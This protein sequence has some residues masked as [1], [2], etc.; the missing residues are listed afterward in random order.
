MVFLSFME[1]RNLSFNIIEKRLFR[2]VN[3][4]LEGFYSHWAYSGW[5]DM[6]TEGWQKLS[7]EFNLQPRFSVIEN[8]KN[9]I[10]VSLWLINHLCFLKLFFI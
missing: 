1:L 4:Y 6:A 7:D 10:N 3:N 5:V 2:F 8:V 9:E